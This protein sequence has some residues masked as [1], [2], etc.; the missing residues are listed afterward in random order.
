MGRQTNIGERETGVPIREAL[1]GTEQKRVSMEGSR[2]EEQG[3]Q[4]HALKECPPGRE[5]DLVFVTRHPYGFR[6]EHSY[7]WC[8]RKD[9]IEPAIPSIPSHHSNS[10]DALAGKVSG[11][12]RQGRIQPESPPAQS[13]LRHRLKPSP[14]KG[15]SRFTRHDFHLLT[16]TISTFWLTSVICLY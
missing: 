7:A 9:W 14:Q 16:E 1:R 3:R 11:M 2:T 4:P 8:K 15:R 12:G 10:K 5:L 6:L 13:P